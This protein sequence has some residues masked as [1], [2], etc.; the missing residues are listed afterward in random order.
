MDHTLLSPVTTMTRI[1]ADLQSAIAL[2]T[3]SL[4]GSSIPT[5]EEAEKNRIP[6]D[7]T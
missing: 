1:P 6:G 5:C 7:Y 4:G 3:S 2:F